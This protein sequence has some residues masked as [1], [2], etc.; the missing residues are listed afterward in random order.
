MNIVQPR[1]FLVG[2]T[3]LNKEGLEDFLSEI[4]VPDWFTDAESEAEVIVEGAGKL[5]YMS[6]D[7]SLNQNLTKTGTRGNFDYIQGGL[8]GQKHTSVLEHVSVNLIF[9]NVSRVFT[10][11]LVRHR[12]GAAYS[13]TSGRYVR[14]DELN[15]WI[16]TC[17][18]E[19]PQLEALFVQAITDQELYLRQMV[20]VAGLDEMTKR[21]DFAKKKVLT[22]ALRRIVGNGVAN[23]I[24]ASYNHRALRHIIAMRTSRDAEEE[25][26][27]VFNDVYGLVRDRYPAIY[28]DAKA[29]LV[30]GYYEIEFSDS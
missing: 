4:G 2:E 27:M 15:F 20:K 7:T 14:T 19:N 25:I 22:S 1:V 13:Q 18:R 12:A 10:H 16:P 9:A 23:H 11:E 8:I 6:F 29:T 24:E 26:R 5:C 28:A 30:N 17:I 21:G 3:K